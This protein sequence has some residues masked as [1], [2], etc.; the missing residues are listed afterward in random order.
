MAYQP[1]IFAVL[2]RR[3]KHEHH[4]RDRKV[5]LN[6]KKNLTI[7]KVGGGGGATHRKMISCAYFFLSKGKCAKHNFW[8]YCVM[9]IGSAT[10]DQYLH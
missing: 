4:K 1:V 9:V 5:L 8:V 6:F 7:S 3:R 10:N 2:I